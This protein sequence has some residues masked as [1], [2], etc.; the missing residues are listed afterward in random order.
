MPNWTRAAI[1]LGSLMLPSPI[2]A[3]APPAQPAPPAPALTGSVSAGLGVTSGNK[4][5]T[6]FNASYELK[7]DPNSRNVVKSAG[8]FLYGKTDGEL[9]SEQYGLS[10]RDEYAVTP[11]AF[12]FGEVR[13]L[14]DRFKGISYLLS[15]TAGVGYKVVD[16][17]DTSL[18]VSA[19]LGGIWEKDY[20]LDLHTSGAASLDEKLSHNLSA[21]AAVGQ[22]FAA[23]WNVSDFGDALYLFGVNLT[24]TLVGNAQLKVEL[25]DSYK[26]RP[27]QPTLKSNDVT[28][29]TGIVYK[30]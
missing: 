26:A 6:S 22:S 4:D 21:S 11:R 7:Y 12:A 5:T 24:A 29:L 30:F 20:G 10:V 14:H 16:G 13:Y 19:G 15:P 3:Q 9:T 2:L 1:A 17:K 27:P 23:L 28:F 25:Q 18:S 8:L